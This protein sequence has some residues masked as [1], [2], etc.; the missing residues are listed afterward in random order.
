MDLTS[1]RWSSIEYTLQDYLSTFYDCFPNIIKVTEGFLGKQEIDSISSSAVIRV[2]AV[3]T[4]KRV[5]AESKVGKLFSLPFKLE[6]VKFLLVPQTDPVK[7]T[8][9]QI[10][11]T[12]EAI[13]SKHSLP[14]TVFSA[15]VLSV[16]E[17]GDTGSHNEMISELTLQDTYEE[18][19]LLGYPFDNGKL[20]LENPIMIP[21]YM[22]EL[23]LVVAVGLM[24]GNSKQWKGMCEKLT[25]EI[26]SHGSTE[27]ATYE[28]IFVLDKKNLSSKGLTYSS[29]EPIYIDISEMRINQMVHLP[30]TGKLTMKSEKSS[31]E[32]I[33]STVNFSKLSDIPVDL[34]NLTV[35]Q[36]GQCL[37]LLNM[38]QYVNAFQGAQ[39]D[40]QLLYELDHEIM[41]SSLGMNG[42]NIVKL[43]KFRDGW[44]PNLQ[45]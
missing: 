9:I 13:L 18:T 39:V 1:V 35:N 33:Q 11:M 3:Y 26:K 30:N 45:A 21:M 44:R 6:N 24:N 23:K 15:K 29:I 41:K 16:K 42:L 10:P 37:V 31:K 5:I 19:F 36:V 8:R 17:K 28:E 14:I 20:F 22:T 12:L 7:G 2:H 25:T 40:G 43:I 38:N 4:Q 27:Q 32:A 34:H